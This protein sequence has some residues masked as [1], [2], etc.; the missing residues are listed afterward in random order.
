MQNKEQPKPECS[1]CKVTNDVKAIK[2]GNAFIKMC[3]ACR[4]A[5]IRELINADAK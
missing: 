3:K 4:K 5:L 2:V 1:I